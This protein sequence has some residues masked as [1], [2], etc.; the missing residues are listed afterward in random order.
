MQGSKMVEEADTANDFQNVVLGQDLG[1]G[2]DKQVRLLGLNCDRE[3]MDFA[4]TDGRLPDMVTGHRSM[5][6]HAARSCAAAAIV[7]DAVELHEVEVGVVRTT[8]GLLCIADL[9]YRQGRP[10]VHLETRRIGASQ[11]EG[12]I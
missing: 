1:Q 5:G 4:R 12:V 2:C 8:L 7:L 10:E 9:P 11:V 3:V 6:K